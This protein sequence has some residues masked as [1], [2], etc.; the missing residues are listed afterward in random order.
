[1][2]RVE[3]TRGKIVEVIQGSDLENRAERVFKMVGEL[4]RVQER[5]ATDFLYMGQIL[6]LIHDERLHADYGSHIVSFNDFLRE[7]GFRRSW[8]YNAIKV[9]KTFGGYQIDGISH[10]RLVRL[11]PLNLP[12]EDVPQW[13]EKARELPAGGFHAEVQEA[14]GRIPQN[15]CEHSSQEIRCRQCGVLLGT[16]AQS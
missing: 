3:C 10:D 8:A 4:Q 6:A 2:D 16:P 11:L 7:I 9:F 13:I 12:P 14:K 15:G 1:M 5:I